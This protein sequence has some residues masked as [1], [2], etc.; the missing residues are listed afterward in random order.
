MEAKT[1][2]SEIEPKQLFG[3]PRALSDLAAAVIR[4]NAE[5]YRAIV[6]RFGLGP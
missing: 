2:A 1:A 5:A 6:D 4:S 3:H